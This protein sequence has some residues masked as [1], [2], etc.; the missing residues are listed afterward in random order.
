MEN[1]QIELSLHDKLGLV[2][3][4]GLALSELD[5]DVLNTLTDAEQDCLYGVAD[6]LLE[7]FI[8]DIINGRCS[9]AITLKYSLK[10]LEDIVDKHMVALEAIKAKIS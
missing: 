3:G 4:L 10:N 6:G 8:V 5:S 7:K 2:N 1:P 9:R